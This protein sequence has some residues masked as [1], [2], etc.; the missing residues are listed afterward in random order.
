MIGPSR[1][2][3]NACA[4]AGAGSKRS[5]RRSRWWCLPYLQMTTWA[6]TRRWGSPSEIRSTKSHGCCSPWG[7]K[8]CIM[9]S[10]LGAPCAAGVG[11]RGGRCRMRRMRARALTGQGGLSVCCRPKPCRNCQAIGPKC[12]HA[13]CMADWSYGCPGSS[14]Q[15]EHIEHAEQT[16]NNMSRPR[17]CMR[18]GVR[19]S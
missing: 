19:C 5:R 11:P 17:F 14:L 16:E 1:S 2:D 8:I 3:P 12:R 7:C 6:A 13:R 18:A 15:P 10:V 4:W 9:L